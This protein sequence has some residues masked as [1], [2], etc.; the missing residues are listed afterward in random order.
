MLREEGSFEVLAA[1]LNNEG[2]LK[3]KF[4]DAYPEEIPEYRLTSFYDINFV[5]QVRRLAKHLRENKVDLIHT[6]DFYT[7]V[8]G[9]AA[10]TLAGTPGRL[11]SKRESEGMRSAAQDLIEKIAFGRAD[12]ILVNSKAVMDHLARRNIPTHKMRL[13][14]NG[15]DMERSQETASYGAD[16][17]LPGLPAGENIR[18]VTLVANLRHSVKNIPMLLRAAKRVKDLHQDVRFLIA[19]EGE[20]EHELR[21]LTVGLGVSDLVHFIG[22]CDNVPAL[23]AASYA[24]VLTSTAEGFSNSLIEYMAAGKPIVATDV[25]G[26]AEAIDDGVTGYLVAPDDDRAMAE[27]LIELLSDEGK[28]GQMGEEGR[29]IAREKFSHTSQLSKTLE[30]YNDCLTK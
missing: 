15:T 17:S 8:F 30:L 24:C 3:Q 11:A 5:R 14:Y 18:F 19:G 10:A 4:A 25:G 22:R 21:E 13:I 2:V 27:H 1:T 9:M 16:L 20:L 6:H 29:K 12:A 7:N 23:L 28:A 26:A